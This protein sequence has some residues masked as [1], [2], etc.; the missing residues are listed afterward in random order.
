M[1]VTRIQRFHTLAA[2]LG[3]KR[4]SIIADYCY[5]FFFE[6]TQTYLTM[7]LKF[8]QIHIN[9]LNFL[10]PRNIKNQ[11]NTENF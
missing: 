1:S 9:L 11:S 8:L 10:L 4:E 6:S 5:V 7:Y 3:I 2:K